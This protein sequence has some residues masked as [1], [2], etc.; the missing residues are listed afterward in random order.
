MALLEQ[1][2]SLALQKRQCFHWEGG[3]DFLHFH[4]CAAIPA[5]VWMQ[6]AARSL[7]AEP[8]SYGSE[9]EGEQCDRVTCTD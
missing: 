1:S 3:V 2:L 4:Q 6:W 9:T 5:L 8:L 7:L